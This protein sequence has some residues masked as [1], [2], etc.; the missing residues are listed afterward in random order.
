MKILSRDFTIREKIIIL[1]LLVL[2]LGLAYYQFVDKPVRSALETAASEKS[3]LETELTAVK[4]KV[5]Q[6][7]KMKN[8]IDDI[9][10]T[11][12][13]AKMP[14][15]DNSKEVIALLND[16][17]GSTGY[18]ITFSNR[19]QSGNMVRRN[20]TL[21]FTADSRDTIKKV[22]KQLTGSDYRCLVGDMSISPSSSSGKS[23]STYTVTATVTFYETMVGATTNQ[24]L[25]AST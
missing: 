24:G 16:V 13:Y 15:Y 25:N 9:T 23:S 1:V 22:F 12:A 5:A 14:S 11:G 10:R 21:R 20:I 17:L 4:A 7:E 8:E 6:L 2:L 3:A 18:S 19:V